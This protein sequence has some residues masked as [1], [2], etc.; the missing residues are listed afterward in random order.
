MLHTTFLERRR[1]ESLSRAELAEHQ[2]RRLNALLKATLPRNRF[3][4][5]KLA[6]QL[7][8]DRLTDKEGSLR[9]LDE[10][11]DWPFTFKEE[12]QPDAGSEPWAAN[13]TFSRSDYLRFHQTSGTRGR[14]MVVLDTAEDWQ[15]WL[16][17]W[18]YVFDAAGIQPDDC[19]LMAFSFG[20]FIGFWSAFEAA[21]AAAAWWCR[22]AV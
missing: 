15:W 13:L 6:A 19:C 8:F 10:L 20:P 2:R 22:P 16:E 3:Y 17:C 14:P 1:L 18:Q 7:D 4:A 9:S 11:A 21:L 5:N 12:L